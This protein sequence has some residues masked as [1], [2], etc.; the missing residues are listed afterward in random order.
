MEVILLEKVKNLGEIGEIVKVKRGHARNYL[1]RYGKALNASKENIAFVNKKKI[2]LNKKN[3]DL[4]KSA[5]KIFDIINLK[6]YKFSK[7][8]MENNKLYGS[9][10]P[11]E[12]VNEINKTSN[13]QIKT[14]SIDL[15][16]EINKT[17]S[18][19]AK[20]NLHAEIQAKILIEVVREN[21]ANEK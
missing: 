7:M 16:K 2:E 18:Y 6:Q 4:K 12:I 5:K 9:V 13:V 21:E 20:I 3:I 10:K 15:N 19:T 17:G 1:I 8:A 11:K 14:S